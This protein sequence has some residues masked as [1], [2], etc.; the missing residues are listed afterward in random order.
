MYFIIYRS[1][2]DESIGTNG[3]IRDGE[4]S[5]L[6]SARSVKNA[7]KASLNSLDAFLEGPE[8][9]GRGGTLG[10]KR[11]K[12]GDSQEGSCR[13]GAGGQN[14]LAQKP[15][16]SVVVA[17]TSATQLGDADMLFKPLLKYLGI[18]KKPLKPL[19]FAKRFGEVSATFQLNQLKLHIAETSSKSN[20]KDRRGKRSDS[21]SRLSSAFPAFSCEDMG[22]NVSAKETNEGSPVGRVSPADMKGSLPG[23]LESPKSDGPGSGMV[24]YV[25]ARC[26]KVMQV[27]DMPF[28]RVASQLA[29]VAKMIQLKQSRAAAD[30]ADVGVER[31]RYDTIDSEASLGR[32]TG[33]G[34]SLG[35]MRG[36]SVDNSPARGT[37]GGSDH[38]DACSNSLASTQD[39]EGL[40]KCWQ[41][42]YHLINL[43]SGVSMPVNIDTTRVLI[44]P[45]FN[46]ENELQGRTVMGQT[47]MER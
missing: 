9:D 14:H 18:T 8:V 34:I 29:G 23:G 40:P 30:Y 21:S 35:R 28:L 16:A 39:D 5:T 3:T 13:I 1:L 22:F 26:G 37:M 44:N 11:L 24:I 4:K 31:N 33:G 10:Y 46:V 43:Y 2:T 20:R 36:A 6:D 27:I 17:T 47:S 25:S 7:I 41:T 42:M 45:V 32:T 12:Y 15:R 19:K 38:I